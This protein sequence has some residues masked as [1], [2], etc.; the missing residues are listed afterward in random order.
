MAYTRKHAEDTRPKR[1]PLHEQRKSRLTI[2]DKDPNYVYRIVNDIDNRITQLK[3]AGYEVVEKN[4]EVGEPNVTD[5]NI[6]LGSG[7]RIS[8]GGGIQ[9]I[10]MRIPREFYEEDQKAKAAEINRTEAQLIKKS[11]GADGTYGEVSLNRDK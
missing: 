11:N 6:T 10:L 4:H 8:V 5:N 9:G 2:V 1:V 3:A 7:T